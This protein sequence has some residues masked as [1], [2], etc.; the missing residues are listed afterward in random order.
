MNNSKL[1]Q[2]MLKTF[3]G[4]A[5]FLAISTPLKGIERTQ[6][7]KPNILFILADDLGKEW[8]SSYGAKEIETPNIDKL[9]ETGLMFDN[10]YVMPQ[11]TPT[12]VSLFTGQYPFRHGWVN[13]WDVP[14]WGGGAH[15]DPDKNQSFACILQ[16]AG[17]KNAAAGKWQVN[18]FRVQ[19]EVMKD[20]GFDDYCMWTGYETGNPPSAKRYWNPYIHTKNGSK[21]YQGQ[22]GEDVFVDFF[23]DFMKKNKNDPMFLYYAMCLP[24]TP[25]TTTPAEPNVSGNLERHKAMV[26]YIDILVGRLENAL[27]ELGLKENTIIIFTTD[28]GSTSSIT[29]TLNGREVKGGKTQTTENGICVPFIVNCPS[30][31]PEG[32][33]TDALSDITDIFPTF[34][35]MAEAKVPDN[36]VIDGVSQAKLFTGETVNSQRD[37]ILSMGGG[38]NAALSEKGVENKY[39]FRDRVIRDKEYKLFVS[40]ERKPEKLGNLK[41]DPAE[42][43][44]L[45]PADDPAVQAKLEKLWKVVEQLPEKDNDPIYI[46][47]ASEPWDVKVTVKSQ[48]WKK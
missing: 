26:R 24:H 35:E 12:R 45:L 8:I 41:Q 39:H 47:L 29:G 38:N 5:C 18:D 44:N 27:V 16:S 22:F 6:P 7:G 48:E 40:P 19:P 42:K 4:A 14:R 43:H 1:Q 2:K 36:I 17:Y 28:N 15:F 33:V 25:F 3:I 20:H 9:A 31:V 13:H 46:P 11:C 10:F 34:I 32:K 30:L 37:W 23:I 21:T